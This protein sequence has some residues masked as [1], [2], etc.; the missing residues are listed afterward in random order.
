MMELPE[1]LERLFREEIDQHEQ[2][3]HMPYMT[4]VE[5]IG[6]EKGLLEGIEV[7][8]RVKFGAEGS[9]LLPEIRQISDLERLRAVLQAIETAATPEE[10]RRV[11][12]G[13]NAS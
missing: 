1:G 13:G 7:L 6:V 11:Y 4:G 9:Q 12:A 5:R 3:K 8:L 2:E 10:L